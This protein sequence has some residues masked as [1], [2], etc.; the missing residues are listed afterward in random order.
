LQAG[1]SWRWIWLIVGLIAVVLADQCRRVDLPAGTVGQRH[2][3]L[4]AIK[5]I[6]RDGYLV[7]ALALATALMVEGGIDTWGVLFLRDALASGLLVGAAAYVI[8]Q[9]VATSARLTF[10]PA[11]GS[12]GTRRGVAL[13][14]GLTA[15]GLTVMAAAPAAAFAA[16]GLVVAAAGI[17][18]CFPL[19]IAHVSAEVDRP[20]LIIGGMTSIG[21]IGF[22]VGPVIV[23]WLA[24]TLGLRIGL[25]FLAAAA[26]FVAITPSRWEARP[27]S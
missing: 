7:I 20:A 17:S 25:L 24:D 13:G 1:L 5:T 26:M 27:K 4:E 15:S 18:V 6:S 2:G 11:A 21:Y 16:I 8:G 9:S 10:G 19:L 3:L 12:F 14:A 22:V 23:G